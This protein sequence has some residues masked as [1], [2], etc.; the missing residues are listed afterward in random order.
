M[1][2]EAL[3]TFASDAAVRAFAVLAKVHGHGREAR[4]RTEFSLR[5]RQSLLRGCQ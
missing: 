3:A 5:P 4:S 2:G 1:G